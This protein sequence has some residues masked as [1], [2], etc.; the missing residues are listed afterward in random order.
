MHCDDIVNSGGSWLQSWMAME[1]FFAEGFIASLGVSNF[2]AK[3]LSTISQHGFNIPHAVQN[4]ADLDE[5]DLDVRQWC[6]DN[7]V[8]FF[9][10]ASRRNIDRLPDDKAIALAKIAE[11]YAVAREVIVSKFFLQTGAGA[12][13]RTSNTDHLVENIMKL[14]AFELTLEEMAQLGWP[15]GTSHS[16][17]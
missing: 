5:L 7:N 13:P 15:F 1:R 17:L 3:L 2:D 12:I 8:A 9:P 14:H 16:E 4:Y 11:K 10:Y 6:S